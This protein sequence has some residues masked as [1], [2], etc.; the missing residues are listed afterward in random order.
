MRNWRV[1]DY[2]HNLLG[3]VCAD[4]LGAAMKLARSVWPEQLK[5]DRLFDLVP[6]DQVNDPLIKLIRKAG[7]HE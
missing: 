6:G 5:G 2:D 4:T 3:E 7:R 1:W